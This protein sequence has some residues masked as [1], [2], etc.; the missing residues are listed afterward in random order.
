MYVELCVSLDLCCANFLDQ[1]RLKTT[2]Y[3]CSTKENITFDFST[4]LIRT[5]VVFP[6]MIV[7]V[8]EL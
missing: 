2:T 6:S 3:Y 1:K 8:S 7:E 5:F 4:N